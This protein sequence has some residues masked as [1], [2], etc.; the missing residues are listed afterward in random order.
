MTWIFQGTFRLL[1]LLT[2]GSFF[3]KKVGSR[4]LDPTVWNHVWLCGLR[5][6]I[7]LIFKR[8]DSFVFCWVKSPQQLT[9]LIFLRHFWLLTC[10]KNENNQ[11]DLQSFP[12][13]ESV[14]FLK[15]LNM[16]MVGFKCSL[17]LSLL[18]LC[19]SYIMCVFLFFF[20]F[21]FSAL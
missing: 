17:Q 11:S 16:K 20:L 3:L 7:M 12:E 5:W 15:N 19:H 18:W 1:P 13:I 4:L 9:W 10:N 21:F 8:T 2:L 6:V 14:T